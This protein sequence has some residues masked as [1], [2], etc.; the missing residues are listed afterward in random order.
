M[1]NY[2]EINWEEWVYYDETSPTFLRWKVDR[3]SGYGGK[4]LLKSI[5]D[6]A[7]F[8]GN[9]GY[10]RTSLFGKQYLNHRIIWIMFNGET[11]VDLE[12]DN[13]N[14]CRADNSIKNLRIVTRAVNS[15]NKA[16]GRKNKTGVNGVSLVDGY[17]SRCYVAYWYD[18]TGKS[19]SKYFS[20]SKLGETEAFNL[21]CE[22]RKRKIEEL[23]SLGAG[24][25]DRHGTL[26]N[27]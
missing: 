17:H 2:N 3:F 15:R 23:N 1:L 10:S 9:E 25:S 5:G 26:H 19:R 18:L 6:V 24:Y 13:I 8:I 27:T 11:S 7:G 20:V 14:G 12:V 21:A 16:I 4:R 22:Y